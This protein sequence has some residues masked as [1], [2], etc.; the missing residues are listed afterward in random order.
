MNK[1]QK[2]EKVITNLYW[3]FILLLSVEII[4]RLRLDINIDTIGKQEYLLGLF[5]LSLVCLNAAKMIYVYSVKMVTEKAFDIF[6]VV[7]IVFV[8][9]F[10]V[11][12]YDVLEYIVLIIPLIFST[13]ARGKKSGLL[14]LGLS[15]IFKLSYILM[16]YLW[17]HPE[18]EISVFLYSCYRFICIYILLI[19][20][21]H[22]KAGSREK[23]LRNENE[24][25][26][27]LAELGE[28]YEQLE[29]AQNEIKNQ[30]DKLKITNNKL[31]DTNRRLT[32]SIAE[33]Y[34][35]Q[36]ISEAIS[37]IFDI[38]ELLKFVNDV[39]IGVMGVNYSTI[40]LLDH[41]DNKLKVQF[42]NIKDKEELEIL[43]NNINCNMLINTLE[44]EKS[45]M[46]N[47]VDP[48]KYEFIK[49]RKVGSLICIP[50]SSK[51][52]KF[53][54]TLIEHKNKNTFTH[55]NLRLV[56]TIGKQV[57]MA[58]ENARLYANL[59]ELATVDGLTGVN[60]R[61]YFHEKYK[62]EFKA[63]KNLGYNLSLV[64]LDIDLFKKFNDTYGHL[65]GDIVLKSVA[66]T[67]KGSLKETDLIARFGGE[68]FV[69]IL[70]DTPLKDA[71]ER[72]E[73]FRS[74]IAN[75]IITDNQISA[76]VTAS[77]GIAC[78]PE[79]SAN[80]VDLIRDADNALYKAKEYGRNNVQTAEYIDIE[81]IT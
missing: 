60:N 54:L 16:Y 2:Y 11:G 15:S 37:S 42:T 14:L 71:V 1:I 43:K 79:T 67:I 52:R 27:L 17:F 30:Y 50:L 44:N 9:V 41:T 7:E 22:V 49:T 10:L 72:V 76:S 70:P 81:L 53:G 23:N 38:R 21:I 57:S 48:G 32:L 75:N 64:I 28:K 59:Q 74:K 58:I 36:Q 56:K 13:L 29:A 77:F 3:V 39:I 68:E 8:S 35:L 12:F 45:I 80:E 46:D 63:A 31:E 62:N 65:F 55:E 51:S 19:A 26:R 73:V 47:D 61:V 34:T 6:R 33:F 25:K 4:I 5:I 40:V 69:I 78:Y 20:I 24:N 66:Q 18:I